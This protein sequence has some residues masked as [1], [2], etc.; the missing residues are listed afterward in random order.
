MRIE[1]N[2]QATVEALIVLSLSIFVLGVIVF[3][4]EE[5]YFGIQ[6]GIEEIQAGAAGEKIT[7]AAEFMYSQGAGS[8]M[9]VY[10]TIPASV[11]GINIGEHYIEFILGNGSSVIRTTSVPLGGHISCTPGSRFVN[12]INE[13]GYVA[14][15][16]GE[17]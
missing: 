6:R 7:N 13:G 9:R 14:I 8:Q 16:E 2:G 5:R 11:R 3:A 1:A 17:T 15:K 4:N 10:I 12:V